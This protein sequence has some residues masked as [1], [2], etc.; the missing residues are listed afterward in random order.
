LTL[1]RQPQ[2]SIGRE[3]ANLMLDLLSSHDAVSHRIV[4]L[5]TELSEG[6]SV[7]SLKEPLP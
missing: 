4:T 3:A 1:I 2:L 6:H 5:T 7:R